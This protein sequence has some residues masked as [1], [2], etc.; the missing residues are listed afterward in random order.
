MA[1]PQNASDLEV[2]FAYGANLASDLTTLTYGSNLALTHV[3]PV[4][5]IARG[6]IGDASQTQPTS[7]RFDLK[8]PS[9][10]F[11]PRN[12]AGLH[13][14]QLRRNTPVRVRLDPG[15]GMVT[16]AIAYLPDWPVRWTG[17]D[18]DDRIA[19]Q[20]S[21]VLQRLG[22]GQESRS[23]IRRTILALS[24][25]AYW[26]LEDS[27]G[28]RSAASA[29]HDQDRLALT[30]TSDFGS[31]STLPG[32]SPLAGFPIVD[33][34]QLR[35]PV[36]FASTTFWAAA[37]WVRFPE[38]PVTA[39]F[40]RFFELAAPGSVPCGYWEF[41]AYGGSGTPG[42]Q[43]SAEGYSGGPYGTT[44][45]LDAVTGFPTPDPY[46][47]EWHHV[48]LTVNQNGTDIDSVLYVDGVVEAFQTLAGNIGFPAIVNM[49]PRSTGTAVS[50]PCALGH[51]SIHTALPGLT[52]IYAAGDG[53][54]GEEAGVR[55]ARLCDEDGVARDV[56]AGVTELMGPQLPGTITGLLRECEDSAEAVVVERR[57]GEV[58]LNPRLS[59]YNKA[60]TLT[61]TY[62][63]V[64][65]MAPGDDDRDL[66]N[67]STISRVGGSSATYELVDGPLGTRLSTGVGRYADPQSRSL[68]TDAQAIQHASMLVN[69]GTVDEPRYV[70]KLNLRA[71]PELITQWLACD[72]GSR[73]LVNNP[74]S[75]Q[76]GP[77]PLD[78]I[79]EGYEEL[80]DGVE[81]LV[82]LYAMPYRPYEVQQIETGIGNR[83]RIPAGLSVLDA[84]R[85]AT[86]TSLA[87]TSLEVRWIDSATYA[88]QFP[89]LI[90]VAGEVMTCTAITGTGLSQTFTVTRG[91]H[92]QSKALS[93]DSLVQLW[94]APVVGL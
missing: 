34:P 3:R 78:L 46:D 6:R 76:T 44:I 75:I 94:R 42:F 22:S 73:V 9:G 52:G 86:A 87:V 56:T 50:V 43:I 47:G 69:A 60:A 1:F 72:I 55:F 84:G 28:A 32:S 35:G 71:H 54:D 29:L 88:A 40:M 57:T 14:G 63:Q 8:N 16:R 65:D 51:A 24:P 33:T 74:P 12:I 45:F 13:Y 36:T 20:A 2:T 61:L 53:Y 90:E 59:R 79:L 25:A 91:L 5:I 62:L 48:M 85:T 11:S 67:Y 49:G 83:S 39:T 82:V 10:I 26:P 23:A 38:R 70:I 64:A 41:T 4:I 18:I 27:R 30:G 31:D 81:W 37:V 17:P 77:A 89:I 93:S 80:L 92:G 7:I 19:M 66:V 58:G 15:T 21:G 68:H